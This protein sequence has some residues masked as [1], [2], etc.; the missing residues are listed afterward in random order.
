M[1]SPEISPLTVVHHLSNVGAMDGTGKWDGQ[2]RRSGRERRSVESRR[3]DFAARR[4]RVRVDTT[5]DE[6]VIPSESWDRRSHRDRRGHP[7]YHGREA[8]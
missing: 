5:E 7:F 4:K 6:Y 1:P 3:V 2:E 8:P